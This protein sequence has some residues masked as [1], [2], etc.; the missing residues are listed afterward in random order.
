MDK[1]PLNSAVEFDKY[2]QPAGAANDDTLWDADDCAAFYK[3]SRWTFVNRISK[4]PDFPA[5]HVETG[6]RFRRWLPDDIRGYR[7]KKRR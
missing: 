5:P 1:P 7:T 3:C 2:G 6:R 4:R